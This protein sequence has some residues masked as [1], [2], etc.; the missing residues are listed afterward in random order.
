[1]A[2]RSFG[3]VTALPFR[4][5]PKLAERRGPLQY[6]QWSPSASVGFMAPWGV[7]RPRLICAGPLGQWLV[8]MV[9]PPDHLPGCWASEGAC[10]RPSLSGCSNPSAGGSGDKLLDWG[11]GVR[12]HAVFGG[13]RW[14][15]RGGRRGAGVGRGT[16]G[17]WRARIGGCGPQ[18]AIGRGRGRSGTGARA[19]S[20]SPI[21]VWRT[22]RA[23]L[24]ATVRA[25]RLPSIRVLTWV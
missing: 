3:M 7:V 20:P 14:L 5:R 10:Q 6:L 18:A 16:S 11:S 17:L 4:I 24:R 23:S 8:G 22:R 12:D 13:R 2:A 25:A 19:A 15:G 21:R 9:R 1:L